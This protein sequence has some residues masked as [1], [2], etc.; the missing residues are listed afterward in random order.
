MKQLIILSMVVVALVF[1]ATV[2]MQYVGGGRRDN[3][4]PPP[5]PVVHLFFPMTSVPMTSVETTPIQESHKEGHHDFWF[6][7]RTNGD[8]QLG[9]TSMNKCKCSRVEVCVLPAERWKGLETRARDQLAQSAEVTFQPL[10]EYNPKDRQGVT[11]PAGAGGW[12]RLVWKKDEQGL[13]TLKAELW[14]QDASSEA[15]KV[16]LTMS[17][18]FVEPVVCVEE[19][20]AKAPDKEPAKRPDE[21]YV[22][23]LSG[24]ESVQVN[25]LCV[26][27]TRPAFSL[28]PEPG[29]T[30]CIVIGEPEK[31]TA[32]QCK[33]LKLP[34][35]VLSGYRVPVTVHEQVD[36][37]HQLDLGLFRYTEVLKTDTGIDPNFY[38]YG[39][40][41]GP[42]EVVTGEE[43]PNLRG[44]IMLGKFREQDGI[45]FKIRLYASDPQLEMRLDGERTRKTPFFE[46]EEPKEVEQTAGKAWEVKVIIPPGTVEGP[47]PERRTE[48]PKPG[49][50]D[51]AVY[52]Q[53]R[54]KGEETWRTIRVPV[55]GEGTR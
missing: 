4:P 11:V 52:L 18:N 22:G 31:L 28:K 23:K 50:Q 32:E 1:L 44:R 27:Y 16:D 37:R 55:Y 34:H 5:G 2:A 24:G 40:V 7:N 12:V 46:V 14:T 20:I 41:E 17:I 25:F 3:T 54:K 43:N 36:D 42:V 19:E 51:C 33:E 53:V 9:L 48:K 30:P 8:V 47:F 15:G 38:L 35:P 26:S 49:Y 6:E 39:E 10:P 45:A 29:R 21:K 13:Q